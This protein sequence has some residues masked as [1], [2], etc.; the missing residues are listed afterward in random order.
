VTL[1]A[2]L[3]IVLRRGTIFATE[4]QARLLQT[5]VWAKGTA[6]TARDAE[7]LRDRWRARATAYL[8]Q[9]GFADAQISL[10]PPLKTTFYKER[11][12]YEADQVIDVRSNTFPSLARTMNAIPR[13]VDPSQ[14]SVSGT[15]PAPPFIALVVGTAIA[16]IVFLTIAGAAL[17]TRNADVSGA[18]RGM[19][20][21]IVGAQTLLFGL[22]FILAI[23]EAHLLLPEARLL[24]ALA[25]TYGVAMLIV[26][27]AMTSES[28]QQSMFLRR[29]F[30]TYEIAIVVV[31]A[32]GIVAL[33]VPL[34]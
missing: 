32:A 34:T 24:F 18:P 8:R 6:A 17:E 1:V 13:D 30:F 15:F 23:V 16:Y 14:Q 5:T 22:L 10:E 9:R 2:V 21:F 29:A 4:P 19:H 12:Q 11:H 20:P 27:L 7:A 28:W 25:S 31:I 33:R 26:W 3:V